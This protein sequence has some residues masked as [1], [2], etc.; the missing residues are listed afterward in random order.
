MIQE[1]LSEVEQKCKSTNGFT[2]IINV[3]I[4]LLLTS[5]TLMIV[6]CHLIK[7]DLVIQLI[8]PDYCYGYFYDANFENVGKN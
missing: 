5:Y 8:N 6:L 4:T 7:Y 2:D 3:I 1:A